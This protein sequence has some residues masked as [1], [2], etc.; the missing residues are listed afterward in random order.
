VTAENYSVLLN[1]SYDSDMQSDFDDIRF[2]RYD[3]NS[4]ELDYWIESM[5]D[6]SW[7]NVWVEL[8]DSITT[9]NEILAWMYY[10]N[11]TAI[12]H[13]NGIN[14]FLFFD[15]FSN[16]TYFD[17]HWAYPITTGSSATYTVSNGY[18]TISGGSAP[19]I[20]T[21]PDVGLNDYTI[22]FKFYLIV[23]SELIMSFHRL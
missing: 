22:D 10:G 12:D 3:D 16:Q 2:I 4:T 18:L 6:G 20:A 15:D 21:A 8:R 17:N 14:T 9:A 1:I 5:V 11:P 13:S 19:N 7:C 23:L